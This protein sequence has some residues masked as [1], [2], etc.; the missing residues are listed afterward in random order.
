MELLLNLAWALLALAAVLFWHRQRKSADRGRMRS[1]LALGCLLALLFP[2]VSASDDLHPLR[3]EAEE[4]SISKRVVRHAT[5][6]KS[7]AWSPAGGSHAQPVAYAF[8]RPGD[9]LCGTVLA[10]SPASPQQAVCFATSS[11]AP[12]LA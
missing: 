10:L 1:L 8:F 12:P 4:S 6:I 11:R 5:G 7:A 9:E 3:A 2:V